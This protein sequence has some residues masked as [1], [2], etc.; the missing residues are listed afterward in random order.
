MKKRNIILLIIVCIVYLIAYGIGSIK[1]NLYEIGVLKALEENN[2][3]AGTKFEDLGEDWLCPLC[4][5]G[6][7]EFSHE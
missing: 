5:L 3:K 4:S 6:K 2:I 1:K 7:D